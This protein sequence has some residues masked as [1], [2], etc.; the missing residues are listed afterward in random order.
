MSGYGIYSGSNASWEPIKLI[1]ITPLSKYWLDS[2]QCNVG[3]ERIWPGRHCC[4][5]SVMS[6]GSLC[7]LLITH[8]VTSCD[9]TW[10][11]VTSRDMLSHHVTCCHIA[12]RLVTSRDMLSHHVTSCGQDPIIRKWK[13]RLKSRL[14]TDVTMDPIGSQL[15]T[16]GENCIPSEFYTYITYSI[17]LQ[18]ELHLHYKQYYTYNT[19]RI[20][21][22]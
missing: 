17:T 20:R 11:V 16:D 21:Q 9:I 2:H 12:W 15:G 18:T 5:V 19:N 3:G 22:E 13:T 6:R 1:P 8:H 10:H 7:L 4:H 14:L